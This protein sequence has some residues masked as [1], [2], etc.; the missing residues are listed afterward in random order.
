MH[1]YLAVNVLAHIGNFLARSGN[2]STRNDDDDEVH[3]AYSRFVNRKTINIKKEKRGEYDNVR[4]VIQRT[5]GP[6]KR[7]IFIMSFSIVPLY[8][9]T[10]LQLLPRFCSLSTSSSSSTSVFLKLYLSV[11]HLYVSVFIFSIFHVRK[12]K[13]CGFVA[14]FVHSPT[15]MYTE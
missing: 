7:R 15:Q 11:F 14:E 13:T 1:R 8:Y 2:Y 12:R 5:P 4:I 3:H 9:Y 10:L 6:S